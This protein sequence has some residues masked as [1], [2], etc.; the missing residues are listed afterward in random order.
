MLMFIRVSGQW[1]A[2]DPRLDFPPLRDAG[3]GPWIRWRSAADSNGT[4][5]REKD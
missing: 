3:K 5:D 4:I 1:I 2:L